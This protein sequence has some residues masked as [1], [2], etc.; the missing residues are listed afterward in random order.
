[1]TESKD[2]LNQTTISQLSVSPDGRCVAFVLRK[3]LP[4]ADSCTKSLWLYDFQTEEC[5]KLLEDAQFLGCFY[6]EDEKHLFYLAR[7][8][9]RN[10]WCRRYYVETLVDDEICIIP[11]SAREVWQSGDRYVFRKEQEVGESRQS[12]LYAMSVH[13]GRVTQLTPEGVA[14]EQVAQCPAGLFC[15]TSTGETGE[16]GISFLPNEG[17]VPKQIVAEGEYPI[18]HLAADTDPLTG[19][20]RVSFVS[21]HRFYTVEEGE[22]VLLP[23]PAEAVADSVSE[24]FRFGTH[25]D[26]CMH[27]GSFAY[28]A[29]KQDST[30]VKRTDFGGQ[31]A[32][33][34]PDGGSVD[35]FAYL[36]D[37]S[38]C[39]VG[40]RSME[41][42]ELY[43][44]KEN[45]L[46]Q[47]THLNEGRL[48]ARK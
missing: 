28:I 30:V 25:N 14:V 12:G 34:T 31:T 7:G 37:G 36:P 47:L 27:E 42:P 32:C 18:T 40:H 15:L 16:T 38:L 5:Y 44:M 19:D 26:F 39:F 24:A 6:W 13:G 3:P 35:G 1:M 33:C 4:G 21:Q 17:E 43:L 29:E 20:P 9:G 8:V 23:I 2:F 22:V 48:D 45:H 10:T 41:H 11:A 46:H